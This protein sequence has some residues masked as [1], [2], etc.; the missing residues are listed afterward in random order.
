MRSRLGPWCPQ[1]H[2]R[3]DV[4]TVA[5]QGPSSSLWKGGHGVGSALQSE[6]SRRAGQGLLRSV[7]AAEWP[8]GRLCGPLEVALWAR[9]HVGW[10]GQTGG[11][12]VEGLGQVW[13][14]RWTRVG[15][16]PCISAL[17]TLSLLPAILTS[18]L[19]GARGPPAQRPV[20]AGAKC[21]PS[22][23]LWAGGLLRPRGEA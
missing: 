14:G 11:H 9:G 12:C 21:Q 16:R 4:P 13:G 15:I 23:G 10:A 22:P 7:Q 20:E 19:C 5:L 6:L 8:A 18:L 1:T 17:Q 3:M 2:L